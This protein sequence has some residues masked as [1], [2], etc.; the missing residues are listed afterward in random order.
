M[1]LLLSLFSAAR[2]REWWYW[3]SYW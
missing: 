1:F 2:E 3:Y